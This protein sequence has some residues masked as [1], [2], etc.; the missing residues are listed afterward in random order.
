MATVAEEAWDCPGEAEREALA[1]L[2]V[3]A[4]C[5]ETEVVGR[6]VA[7][8][9]QQAEAAR[10]VVLAVE[11]EEVPMEASPEAEGVGVVGAGEAGRRVAGSRAAPEATTV[12]ARAARAM[13]PWEETAV[14]ATRAGVMV[15]AGPP[16]VTVGPGVC[17]H[18]SRANF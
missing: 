15:G 6:A 18:E 11:D 2:G 4:E 10:A 9:E 7:L 8:V 3:G 17:R 14:A 5:T 1:G 16:V 13:A 12:V